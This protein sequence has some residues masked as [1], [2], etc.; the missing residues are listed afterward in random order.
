MADATSETRGLAVARRGGF[1]I[2][3]PLILAV[4][5]LAIILAA[6]ALVPL[7][8]VWTDLKTA[9]RFLYLLAIIIS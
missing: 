4:T 1:T 3:R 5:V 8:I 2:E 9:A 6:L 7:D